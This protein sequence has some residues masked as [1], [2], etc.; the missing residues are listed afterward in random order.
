MATQLSQAP[1]TQHGKLS[2]DRYVNEVAL[3]VY[4]GADPAPQ[5]T[6]CG[7]ILGPKLQALALLVKKGLGAS[8]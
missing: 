1:E 5:D 2:I 6:L 7:P 4:G 8:F 3:V